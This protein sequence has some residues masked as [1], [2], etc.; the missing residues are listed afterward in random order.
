M[1]NL[2]NPKWLFVL[3]SLPLLALLLLLGGE[4]RVIH[5]LLPPAS[6]LAWKWLWVALIS[7][8]AMHAGYAAWCLWRRQPLSVLY[9]VAALVL[10]LG[11]MCGYLVAGASELFPPEVPTWMVGSET[12]L[13]ACTFLMPTV[14]HAALVLIIRSVPTDRPASAWPNFVVAPL[15]PVGLGVLMSPVSWWDPSTPFGR[16]VE[17]VLLATGFILGTL[18]FLLAIARGLY[19]IVSRKSGLWPHYRVVWTALIAGVLPLAGLALNNGLFQKLGGGNSGIFGDFHSPW[20]YI[21]AVLNAV[22]LCLPTPAGRWTRLA[23]LAARSVTLTYTLY[24]F[25]VFLP[26]L[27]LSV[28]ALLLFAT[29]LLMLAPL[30]LLVHLAQ[31]GRDLDALRG[32]F[33]PR[34][35]AAVVGAGLLVLPLALTAEYWHYRRTLHAALDYVYAPDF[36]REY[37]LDADALA[38]T[39]E[40]VQQHKV[41]DVE[42]ATKGQPYLSRYFNWLVLDN[43]TLSDDKLNRLQRIFTGEGTAENLEAEPVAQQRPQL[44][45]LSH[46]STYDAR[47]GHWVS[48]VDLELTCPDSTQWGQQLE[49]ATEFT[50]PPGC[51]V[52][53]YYLDIAGKREHGV[54]AEKKAAAWVYAQSLNTRRDPGILHYLTG[55]RLGLRV[56]PFAPREVRRTGIC[57]VHKEPVYLRFD[58][59]LVHLGDATQQPAVGEVSTPGQE[60][61][62]VSHAAKQ[63]L[64]LAHRRPYYHFLLDV[65]AGQQAHK[66][67]LAAQVQAQLQRRPLPEPPR[68]TLVNTYPRSLPAGADWQQQFRQEPNAG[69]LY[70]AGTVRRILAHE[71]E[72][73]AD[74]YPVLVLVTADASRAVLDADF[75]D[76]ASAYPESPAY[77]ILGPSGEPE[78]YA[79]DMASFQ[80]WLAD[81]L[82]GTAARVRA[83]PAAGKPRAY[84]LDD[85]QASI[86]L[87]QPRL[88]M[89]AADALPASPWLTGLLLE[90]YR[91]H[92]ALRPAEAEAARLPAVRASFRAGILTPLTS[93]LSLENDAQRAA[94]R[95]KQEQVLS[96]H[97]ALDAG[98]ETPPTAVPIDG[99]AV[100][101][102]VAGAGLGLNHLRRRRVMM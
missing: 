20:F 27:P 101:L 48:W 45:R 86:V 64:P 16:A 84:L 31:L 87:N 10:N 6:L 21:L 60:V 67:A 95:R 8:A 72:H 56:F 46:R 37:H 23:L 11:F 77:Y 90:G 14:A 76:L 17:S 32:T 5:S 89:P 38:R 65:S 83:W 3:N 57:F 49:Y 97:A 18:L 9:A 43:L 51:W 40:I 88:A 99:G 34:T 7:L 100:L 30:L 50:V 69:G 47:Q 92:Q 78:A 42:F 73:P 2:L 96:A 94:L 66:A 55:N 29:G 61:M 102:L 36:R 58:F 26:W 91:Q 71:Q 22:L 79:L 63:R 53:D 39:L 35:L 80:R 81:P 1:R 62:Y 82:P 93:Y 59:Q 41:P 13:Y 15:V 52:Q 44:T 12:W 4:F 70:L 85:G 19:I 33:A 24:F 25:L 74:T 68:F 98:E 28:V 54:L 75:A